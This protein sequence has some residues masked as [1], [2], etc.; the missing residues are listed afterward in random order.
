MT[1][2]RHT[3]LP[4][5]LTSWRATYE[6]AMGMTSTGRGNDPSTVTSLESSMMQTKR[7]AAAATTFSRVSAA[8]PPLMSTPSA[9]A[10]SAP[11]I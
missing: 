2:S 4:P 9:V 1:P 10:S 6:R 5:S 7:V 11:S 8:P 3:G